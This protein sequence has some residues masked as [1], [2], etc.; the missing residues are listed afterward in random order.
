MGEARK[1]EI[2]LLGELAI[3]ADGVSLAL[4]PS[5]KT[6]GLLAYLALADRRQRREDLCELLWDAPG[7]PRAA[8]RWSLAK[9]RPLLGHGTTSALLTDRD[10]VA[11]DFDL[12]SVDVLEARS[13]LSLAAG[14]ADERALEALEKSFSAGYLNGL[15][16]LGSRQFQLWLETEKTSLRD[17]HRS[18]IVEMMSRPG[19]PE[20]SLLQLAGKMVALDPLSDASN[21]RYLK[22]VFEA[23]GLSEARQAFDRIA[24]HYRDEQQD[25][26]VL[27]AG[28]HSI[29]RA[30]RS[31]NRMSLVEQDLPRK[32]DNA[33]P[34]KPSVAVLDFRDIG[35]HADGA[36][37]ANGLTVDLNS[38]LAQLPSLFVIARQSTAR[39]SALNL[40]PQQIGAKLGVRYLIS[41]STQRDNNRVRTTITL[42]D[43]VGQGELWS[44]HFDRPLDD[45]FQVQDDI[46]NA[47]IAAIEPA[48]ERAEMQR[49][50]LKPPDSLTAWECFHRGLWHC[51]RFTAE[52]NE[53]AHRL[54]VEAVTV[55]P[56]FSRAFAGLSFT[57]YSRAFLNTVPDVDREV[58]EALEAA[59]H[60]VD[61]DGRDAMGHWALGRALFLSRQHDRA[62]SAIDRALL[63]NPNYAQGHYARGF[64]G[65]HAGLDD[66]SLPSLEMA[67]RLSPF[68][69][70]L[71]AMKSS[72][73]ISLANR[74]RPEEAASW[75]IA[76]TQEPNAHFH[77]Y[78]VAAACLELA[79]RSADARNN[80][81][82][83][84]ERKPAYTVEVFRRS[85][86]HKDESA[87]EN[88]L[89][90]LGRAGLPWQ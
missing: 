85:F 68:D 13:T 87:R 67:Q 46:T 32:V 27:L 77:I 71:F 36:V 44:E 55:D 29:A 7:D 28:W 45:L 11:L 75:A 35:S 78:A 56:H 80:A 82:W 63:V 61:F 90:A 76:G 70:L 16:G 88:F 9:L 47:V 34:E 8:L 42:T 83:V 37:L 30:D 65:I 69:P 6:R 23:E 15:D 3:L 39:I 54:F 21:I 26:T 10:T 14:Q 1:V 4:P 52:D 86:P 66:A 18:I 31:R 62:M 49:A 74:G 59:S 89:A 19:L 57:H 51:F 73:A 20:A 12:V 2:R 41:G 17:L 22:L 48:I 60:S 33:L 50:L 25:H 38:R 5:R 64:V 53:I 81:G 84:L 79:G 24:R 40:A 58:R 43:T 72:R